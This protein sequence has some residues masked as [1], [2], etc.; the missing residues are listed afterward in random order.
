MTNRVSVVHEL[1][2][3]ITVCTTRFDDDGGPIMQLE[4]YSEGAEI[5]LRIRDPQQ[6]RALKAELAIIELLLDAALADPVIEAEE[7]G[8]VDRRS[9]DER[10]QD[11]FGKCHF[12]RSR[13]DRRKED[14]A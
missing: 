9:G 12:R 3:E 13:R 5:K 1:S 8:S 11:P 6:A 14:G 10:R 4:I 2:D 7:V